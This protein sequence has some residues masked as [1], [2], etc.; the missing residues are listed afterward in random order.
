MLDWDGQMEYAID[1]SR[2]RELSPR[3]GPCTM[4]GDFLRYKNN[5]GVSGHAIIRNKNPSYQNQVMILLI[6]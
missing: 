6:S 2:A 1:S 4:C 5:E 3:R